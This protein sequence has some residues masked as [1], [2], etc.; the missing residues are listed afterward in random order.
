M[1]DRTF[2]LR[3]SQAELDKV[4]HLAKHYQC[5]KAEVIRKLINQ[6]YRRNNMDDKKQV[7]LLENAIKAYENGEIIEAKDMA[8]EFINNITDFEMEFEM[9]SEKD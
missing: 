7:Q 8:I 9:E 3:I 5:T 1:N 2:Q 6:A 4:N